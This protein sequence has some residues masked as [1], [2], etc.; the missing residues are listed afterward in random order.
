M[1]LQHKAANYINASWSMVR[2]R[3]LI[4][5]M[6][7]LLFTELSANGGMAGDD[8]AGRAFAAVYKPAVKTVFDA[9]G[10]AHQVMAN[11]AGAM[12][13][14]T[15]NFLKQES[16]IAASL[17]GQ[18]TDLGIGAQPAKPDCDPRA[19]HNA[20]ELPEVVG[21][22][23]WSDQYLFST[24]FHGQ[25]DK[26]RKTANT[27]RSAAGILDDAYWDSESAWRTASAQQLG[28]TATAVQTFFTV[29]VGKTPPSSRVGEDET[30]M[31]NLPSACRMIAHACDAY[32]DHIETALN[33]ISQENTPFSGEPLPLWEQPLFGGE[34]RDGGLHE[35]IAGDMR[36]AGLGDIP[37]ALDA[38]QA[39]VPMP[40]PDGGFRPLP[41][42]PPFIAPLIRTPLLVPVGYRPPNGPRVQPIA[43]P[44]PPNPRFPPLTPPEQQD[45]QTWLNSL[46]AGGVSGGRAEEIAYQMRVAGYP[47]YEVPIPAGIS[48]GNTLMVDGFRD[49]DGMA[50]EAKYVNKP[51]KPCYRSL[52]EL[53]ENH[54]TDAKDFLFRSDRDELKKYNAALNDPR[55]K[56]MRGVE[57]VTNNADSV[58]YWRVM[59][60]AYGVKGYARYEP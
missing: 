3:D 52:A 37:P 48:K 29:F 34:G 49:S 1:N 47:E 41:S 50:I 5:D 43:P 26:L 22:T 33:K 30:L 6:V 20:E 16:A 19:S 13:K 46:R 40:Q 60:A 24:R 55:N 35:L 25:R 2:L 31:A 23:S 27:W 58:A 14:A 42:L 44:T 32:A 7:G 36:I 11:G 17:L 51:G 9:A 10:L 54:R 18:S 28:E 45:F 59:M 38:S 4:Y 39:K 21:E 12:L 57:T 8:N 53:R 15:E 56:E